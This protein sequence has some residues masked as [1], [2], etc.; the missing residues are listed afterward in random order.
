MTSA[1]SFQFVQVFI[2][3]LLKMLLKKEK[4][5]IMS[6]FSFPTAFSHLLE[7]FQ[8]FSSNSKLSSGNSFSIE[9][10]KICCLGKG[11]KFLA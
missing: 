3:S 6:N 7:N 9:E 11:L 1:N 8:P 10:C 4:L 2:T 5:L